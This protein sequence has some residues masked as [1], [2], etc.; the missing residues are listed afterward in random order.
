MW[1]CR[2]F[3]TL[4]LYECVDCDAYVGDEPVEVLQLHTTGEG[5]RRMNGMRR[6]LIASGIVVLVF[7]ALTLG[8]AEILSTP[9]H[10][11]VGE[12]PAELA[13]ESTWLEGAADGPVSGWFSRGTP[14]L[15]AVLLLHGVRGDRRQ[16]VGRA[17][18]LHAAGYSVLLIDLPAH[19]Q[20]GGERITFGYR[21]ADGVK[22]ALRFLRQT[23]PGERI[24]AIGVSLGAASVVLASSGN[25]G[26][27][28]V[29]LESMYPTIEDAA[30]NRLVARLGTVGAE[31][32][33]V[34]LSLLQIRLGIG[35]D[36]LRP[37]DRL[38]ALQAPVLIAAGTDDRYTS[39]TETKRLFDA[40]AEPKE[41]WL[42]KGATH[43]DLHAFDPR[44]YESRV[45]AF[46]LKY[47]RDSS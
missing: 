14:G 20:S 13:A 43:V 9:A 24:A 31:L 39:A 37:I 26:P 47:L 38:S 5:F 30:R 40:A 1:S 27:D 3:G 25:G 10:R 16:M 28:V 17:R 35:A 22:V 41:L 44:A 34:L 19:G 15:G 33:P 7:V 29:V 36:Q 45:S 6:T 18:F 4:E 46:L 42:L 8:V 23:L 21:E 32:T 11:I 12:P 2:T